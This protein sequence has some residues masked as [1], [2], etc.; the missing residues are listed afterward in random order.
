MPGNET[1]GA[2]RR[3]FEAAEAGC[4][5]IGGAMAPASSAVV[6]HEPG[7]RGCFF[8]RRVMQTNDIPIFAPVR[9]NLDPTPSEMSLALCAVGRPVQVDPRF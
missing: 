7:K 2:V 8:G 4:V 6:E 5:R 9:E 3:P 1:G